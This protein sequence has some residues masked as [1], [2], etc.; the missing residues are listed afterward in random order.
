MNKTSITE[1]KTKN[2]F[3]T[4]LIKNAWQTLLMMF[5]LTVTGFSQNAQNLRHGIVSELSPI[6]SAAEKSITLL[7]RGWEQDGAIQDFEARVDT[8]IK[9]SGMTSA[10]IKF[11][12]ERTNGPAGLKQG[13]NSENYRGKRL[14]LSAWI[15]TENVQ[16]ANLWMRFDGSQRMFGFDDMNNRAIK[17]TTDWK[18]YEITMDVPDYTI[19]IAFGFLINGRGQAWVDDFL[20]ET[21]E[22][23]VPVTNLLK[24]EDLK[25]ESKVS[26]LSPAAPNQPINLDFEQ[27]TNS[28]KKIIVLEPKTLDLYAGEY[29]H[30][31]RQ[32]ITI[33]KATDRLTVV[34]SSGEKY[35]LLPISETE[36]LREGKP[37]ERFIFV[38]SEKGRVTHYINRIKGW[39]E[40]NAMKTR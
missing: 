33:T 38:L 36:F 7:P 31:N 5:I 34:E 4:M 35:A 16:S 11:T 30:P 10:R 21:V 18:K 8:T 17:G 22:K 37:Q 12:G 29:L 9:R 24:P 32:K 25:K 19:Y 2:L 23:T 40:L 27:G 3:Q 1:N 14:K 15:K 13:F 28:A 26:I 6:T 39:H 20:F